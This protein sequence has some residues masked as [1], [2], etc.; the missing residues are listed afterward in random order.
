MAQLSACDAPE[1]TFQCPSGERDLYGLVKVTNTCT[2]LS[3][4]IWTFR[5]HI[6]QD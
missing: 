5:L 3:G 1:H 6:E 2:P 4:E